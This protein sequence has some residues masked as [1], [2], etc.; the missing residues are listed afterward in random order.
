MCTNKKQ[1]VTRMEDLPG[2]CS[3]SVDS[4]IHAKIF[5]LQANMLYNNCS[6]YHPNL[7]RHQAEAELANCDEGIYLLRPSGQ[8]TNN[9]AS[10]SLD[11]K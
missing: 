8:Q 6:W 5:D 10:F 9:A 1:T 3:S 4:K 2:G 11:V 7:T